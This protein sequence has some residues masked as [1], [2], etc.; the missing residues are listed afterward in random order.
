MSDA[1][2]LTDK[3]D[4]ELIA[5]MKIDSRRAFGELY[6]RYYD[7][8]RYYCKKY[9]NDETE[10]EDVVQDIYIHLWETRNTLNITSSF[11]G[12]IYAT[13]HNR[14]LKMLRQIDVHLRYAQHIL[15]NA[16]EGTSE[17]EDS[18]IDNDYAVLLNKMIERLSPKQKEV[19]LLSRIEGLTYKEIAERLQI[20]VPAVQKHVSIVLEKIKGFLEKNKIMKVF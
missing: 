4:S 5:L 9:L 1:G 7:Q 20:S 12:Y 17:T 10:A 16:K 13:A 3:Q 2:K 15:M 11:S 14:I 18:I 8:L 6:I 19:F